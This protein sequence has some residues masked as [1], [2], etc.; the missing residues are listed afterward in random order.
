MYYH[1]SE[2]TILGIDCGKVEL[3]VNGKYASSRMRKILT[4]SL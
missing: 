3:V 1:F 2:I 4:N